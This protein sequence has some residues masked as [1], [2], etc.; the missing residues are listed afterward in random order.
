MIQEI[1]NRRSIRKYRIDE[2]DRK[3]IEEI[4]YSATFALSAK[5]K[6]PL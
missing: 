6:Q 5:N 2:V 1:E 4:L 3:I